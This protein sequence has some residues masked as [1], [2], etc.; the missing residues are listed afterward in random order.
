M[1][2]S[3]VCFRGNRFSIK[4]KT[5]APEITEWIAKARKC[6]SAK[7]T[8][9]RCARVC[10][11]TPHDPLQFRDFALSRFRDYPMPKSLSCLRGSDRADSQV[12]SKT[13]R[14]A[15]EEL[16]AK[17]RSS[18]SARSVEDCLLIPSGFL[19]SRFRPFA[20]SR[21]SYAEVPDLSARKR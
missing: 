12:K 4:S 18:H 11:K 10:W 17:T 20:L 7:K 14:G 5:H 16:I 8:S 13:R 6:E 19:I 9:S 15:S 3:L 2:K 1:L 21:L